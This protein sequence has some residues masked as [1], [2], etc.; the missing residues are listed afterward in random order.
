MGPDT[1][2]LLWTHFYKPWF[3]IKS[4]CLSNISA[5]RKCFQNNSQLCLKQAASYPLSAGDWMWQ[6]WVH[7]ARVEGPRRGWDRGAAGARGS[8]GKNNNAGKGS[9]GVTGQR[10]FRIVRVLWTQNTR[11]TAKFHK[12]RFHIF[13][14]AFH[15]M[16][17][18]FVF[19]FSFLRWHMNLITMSDS[20][21]VDPCAADYSGLCGQNRRSV[22]SDPYPLHALPSTLS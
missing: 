8:A 17:W 10:R 11:L 6:S 15:W 16:F 19:C 1:I 5:R 22:S 18:V 14:P 2:N 12:M 7:F 3:P 21:L 9:R 20:H 4:P 13:W